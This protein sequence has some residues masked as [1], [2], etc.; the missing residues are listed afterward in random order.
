VNNEDNIIIGAKTALIN[1]NINSNDNFK[2]KFI[3]NNLNNKVL[4]SIKEELQDCDEFYI[5]VAFITKGGITPLLQDFLELN[6]KGIKG[7]ILTTD[8]L[9][10]TEPEALKKLNSFENIEVKLYSES[11]LGFH[12]KAYIFKKSNIY[13]TILGSSNLTLNAITKNKEWNIGLTSINDGEITK[14]I[15]N[16]FF[17]LWDLADPLEKSLKE[18]ELIYTETKKFKNIKDI[19]KLEKESSKSLIP[20]SMQLDFLENIRNLITK[21]ENKALLIS[22]TGTGKTL[23]SAFAVKEFKPKKFLFLVHREQIAKQAMESYKQII[24]NKDFGLLSGNYKDTSKDYLF[25]TIQTMSKD[26]VYT[27]FHPSEFDFIIIDEVHKAGSLSYQKIMSYFKPKFYLGMSASPERTDSFDIYKL[28][29]HNIA[30][31]IRLKEALKEDLLCPFHY[32]AISD[33]EIDGKINN[34]D[35]SDFNNLVSSKRTDYLIEKSE[36]YGF[37]GSKVKGLVFCSRKDEAQKLSENF[38]KRGFSTTFLTGED[39]QEKREEAIY[40]LTSDEVKNKLDYI[41]TVDIFNEGVDI[42]EINQVLLVRPTKS[43]IIFIQQLGRGLRKNKNKEYVVIL[44]FI[45]NYKNNFMIPI[46]LSGDKTYNKDNLRYFLMEG[47]KI[48]PGSSTINFDKIAKET[49]FKSINNTSF[50]KKALFKEKYNNLKFKLGKIPSLKEFY[51]YGDL[52]PILILNHSSIDNYHSFLSYADKEYE[53]IL[54]DSENN[55]LKFLSKWL[56]SGKRPHELII[57]KFLVYKGYF[58]I[59]D[60]SKVLKEDYNVINDL[61]SIKSAT[62]FLKM[63]FINNNEKKKYLDVSFIGDNFNISQDFKSN[64]K[65]NNFKEHLNDLIEYGLKKYKNEYNKN[66]VDS[67]LSLYSKYSRK[68]VCRLLNWENDDSSTVYGYRIKHDTCPI[69]V[70]Y[71]KDETITSST[72]YA[73]KFINNKM[74]SWMTRSRLRLDSKE[75]K[76]IENHDKTNLAIHLFIKKD[77]GEGDDFYYLG[78]VKPRD[79]RETSILNDKNEML[80]LVNIDLELNNSIKKELYDYLIN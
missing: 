80:P 37:S 49:I 27:K 74:F 64:L 73:E 54:S 63:N 56:A 71:H 12:T 20:N 78:L 58:T 32:F 36:Y 6:E 60:I 70:T 1:E 31:E 38:N 61:E 69:F 50:S 25:S 34:D 66:K 8:Y 39:S 5:S 41:F 22:A 67:N 40:R 21:G 68:D 51:D 19:T 24:K 16:E 47:N 48:I 43:P 76:E 33:I 7:K 53:G 75:V 35:F 10:F 72:K 28:F 59:E 13:K 65:S 77:D 42:P 23:A 55:S 18:Y 4:T 15:L 29:D 14:D 62:E 79:F 9:Y 11:N 30:H 26:D 46:A 2:P 52:D 17:E 3:S 57:L 45:A 44:D